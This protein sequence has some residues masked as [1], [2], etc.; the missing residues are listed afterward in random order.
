MKL[1]ASPTSALFATRQ[2]DN[3]ATQRVSQPGALVEEDV[4]K[5]RGNDAPDALVIQGPRP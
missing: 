1:I 4:R 3:A 5:A 2:R